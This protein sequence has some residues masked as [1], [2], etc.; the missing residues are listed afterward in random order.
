MLRPE[1]MPFLPADMLRLPG[2][3]CEG[4]VPGVFSALKKT[5]T[6]R[7]STGSEH[8]VMPA[9]RRRFRAREFRK[10]DDP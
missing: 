9:L 5:G 2:N 6:S 7:K 10:K 3:D 4:A 1:G 8:L